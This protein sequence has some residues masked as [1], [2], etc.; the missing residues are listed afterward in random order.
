MNAPT[1][2]RIRNVA[3]VGHSGSGK[4]SLAEALLHRAGVLPRAGSTDEGT[5]DDREAPE[6]ED[7]GTTDEGPDGEAPDREAPE[8][9]ADGPVVIGE[10]RHGLEGRRDRLVRRVGR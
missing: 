1:T 7:N 2:D 10:P 9:R 8:G 5:T 4:T 3:L 6:G